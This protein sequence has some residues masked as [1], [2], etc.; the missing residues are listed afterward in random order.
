MKGRGRLY[1]VKGS[2]K[3]KNYIILLMKWVQKI[4]SSV[5]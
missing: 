3:I 1:A 2:R 5:Y 4:C